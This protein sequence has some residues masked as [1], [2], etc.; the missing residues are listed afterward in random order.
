MENL[1]N[2]ILQ[3]IKRKEGDGFIHCFSFNY[4]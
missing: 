4:Y 1:L 2:L 3:N